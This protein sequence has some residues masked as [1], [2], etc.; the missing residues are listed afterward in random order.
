MWNWTLEIKDFTTSK[1]YCDYSKI[2]QLSL[3]CSATR[4]MWKIGLRPSLTSLIVSLW[5][6]IVLLLECVKWRFYQQGSFFL[7]WL[8]DLEWNETSEKS[9]GNNRLP[10]EKM[11]LGTF[12]F[13]T[14]MVNE[15]VVQ[16][17][18]KTP[19]TAVQCCFAAAVQV[20]FSHTRQ[21]KT[22]QI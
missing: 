14:T 2:Q 12:W 13:M 18:H 21:E 6:L 22:A 11:F 8:K 10:Q 9:N 20:I 15:M 4:V 3:L 16:V 17:N 7:L 5:L 19:V 1:L